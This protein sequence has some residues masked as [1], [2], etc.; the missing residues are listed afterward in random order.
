VSRGAGLDTAGHLEYLLRLGD[1]NLVLGQRL[2]EWCGHGPVIEEDLALTNIS[3]DLIGQ[4]RL[5]Y[6]WAGELEGHGRDEDAFAFRR[7][8]L[9]FHNP[10]LVE[11]P[12]GDFGV[13]MARQF[14]F[15][16]WQLPL[17]EQL[18][19]SADE[20]L[21]EIAAKALPEARYHLRH[22]SQW[23][24]RLGDGTDESRARVQAALESLWQFTGELFAADAL[25]E[26]ALAAG[27]GADLA[28]VKSAW[29]GT[30][31]QVLAEATLDRP[32]ERWM[33]SGGKQGEHGEHL[34]YILAE[35][36]F[37]PRAYPDAEQ[38]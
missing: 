10:L 12:N 30:V 6:T 34:G 19:G 28:A 20:R 2:G 36:Q 38:W 17:Y 14:L 8:V 21:A 11:Q 25:D 33:Q 23:L 5:L 18:A 3:L 16:A 7:D 37:L 32:A 4:A 15:D 26:A 9:D 31:D 24:V 22:S 13:T 29:D 35:L 27:V 1:A